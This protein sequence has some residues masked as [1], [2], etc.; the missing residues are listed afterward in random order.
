MRP[1]LKLLMRN[2]KDAPGEVTHITYTHCARLCHTATHCNKL[3]TAT[4]P[5]LKLQHTAT[6][7]IRCNTLQHSDKTI[8]ETADAQQERSP[9]ESDIYHIYSLR[10]TATHC[11]ALQRTATYCNVLQH[12]DKTTTEAAD[13]QQERTPRRVFCATSCTGIL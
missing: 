4:N 6:L 8:A 10:R 11:F 1:S 2:K 9:P 13:A 5:L 12:S 3:H 7:C